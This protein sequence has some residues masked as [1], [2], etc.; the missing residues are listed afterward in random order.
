MTPKFEIG[1]KVLAKDKSVCCGQLKKLEAAYIGPYE[2]INIEGP[3]LVLCTRK[4][5]EMEIHTNR[6]KVFFTWLQMWATVTALL[7]SWLGSSGSLDV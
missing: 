5:K 4:G 6:A 1:T 3:N 2:I 7:I